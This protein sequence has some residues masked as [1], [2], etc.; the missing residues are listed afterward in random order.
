MKVLFVCTGNS[1][2][3][4]VAEALLKKFRHDIEVDSAGTD[5][6]ESIAEVTKRF[7]EKEVAIK[8]LKKLPEGVERKKL[9][10]YD[11][12]IIFGNSNKKKIVERWSKLEHKIEV[13]HIDDPY[14]L[15]KGSE[16]IA[17]DQIKQKVLK[18]SKNL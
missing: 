3:S 13:W 15:P 16:K 11:S 17:F 7:L 18:L 5:P 6:A 10:E 12:I 1:Y 4:P 9:K 8:N 2:R 14:Y